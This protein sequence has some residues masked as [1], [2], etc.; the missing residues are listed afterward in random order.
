MDSLWLQ[1][2]LGVVAAWILLG[3][4]GLFTRRSIAFVGHLLFPVSAVV[5]L[6]LAGIGLAA[7]GAPQQSMVLPLGLPGLPFHLHLDALSAFFLMLIGAA[8]AGI[9]I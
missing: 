5:S 6:S 4:A 9:S 3:V 1:A 7:M 2:A 8:S